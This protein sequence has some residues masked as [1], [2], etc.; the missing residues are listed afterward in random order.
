VIIK[1]DE[2]ILDA[3]Y[4][5]REGDTGTRWWS[6]MR[7]RNRLSVFNASVVSGETTLTGKPGQ[8]VFS[9]GN[10]IYTGGSTFPQPFEVNFVF[11]T[12]FSGNPG[13]PIPG[14]FQSTTLTIG[15]YA[16]AVTVKAGLLLT[17]L[18]SAAADDYFYFNG[19]KY[20][21]VGPTISIPNG[22][23]IA[24]LAAGQSLLV[25]VFNQADPGTAGNGFFTVY[26]G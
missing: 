17:T 21:A 8:M 20:D 12:L 2:R 18:A 26:P 10:N 5:S 13:Y 6:A 11:P 1:R 9:F 3:R 19:I 15:P 23:V 14:T 24:T 16:Y 25:Q 7:G 4:L 22:T